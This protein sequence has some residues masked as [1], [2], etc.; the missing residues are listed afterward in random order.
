ME[1]GVFQIKEETSG[2]RNYKGI[3][4][5]KLKFPTQYAQKN[6]VIDPVPYIKKTI[7]LSS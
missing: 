5:N 3:G 4:V 6:S 2:E 1:T 7:N